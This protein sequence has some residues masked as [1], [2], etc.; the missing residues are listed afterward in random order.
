MNRIL[1]LVLASPNGAFKV[2]L[3]GFGNLGLK[4]LSIFPVAKKLRPM[5]SIGGVVLHRETR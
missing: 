1:S 4:T 3:R 5:T 2:R